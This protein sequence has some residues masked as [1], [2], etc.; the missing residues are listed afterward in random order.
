MEKDNCKVCLFCQYAYTDKYP[1]EKLNCENGE[2]GMGR[3]NKKDDTCDNFEYDYKFRKILEGG[4]NV[5][6]S[7]I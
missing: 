3:M 4:E 2:L 7:K 1:F 5:E 6:N